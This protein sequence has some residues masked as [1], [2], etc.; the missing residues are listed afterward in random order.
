LFYDNFQVSVIQPNSTP[1]TGST[2]SLGSAA[3][4]GI[5]AKIAIRPASWLRAFS[6]PSYIPAEPHLYGI[7]ARA[8]F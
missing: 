5:E 2:V 7:P 3:N 4:K 6:I 8:A 1:R